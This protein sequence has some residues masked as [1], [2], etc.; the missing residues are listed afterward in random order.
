MV[1]AIYSSNCKSGCETPRYLAIIPQLQQ[2][3]R[4]FFNRERLS[5]LSCFS[6]Y[7]LGWRESARQK[8]QDN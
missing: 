4:V 5:L 8:I 3:E 7:G 2:I 1:Q 6:G